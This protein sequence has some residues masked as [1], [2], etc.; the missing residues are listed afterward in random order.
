MIG[1]RDY[2]NKGYGTEAINVLLD[3]IFTRTPMKKVYLNTLDWNVRAQKC[4]KKCG[5][6]EFG[7]FERDGSI[8]LLMTLTREEWEALRPGRS[9][10]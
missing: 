1:D 2:W 8:F 9:I 7:R 6:T 4:F 3:R 5:F 10:S